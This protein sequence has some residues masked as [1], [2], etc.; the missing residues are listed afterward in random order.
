M[1]EFMHAGCFIRITQDTDVESPLTAYDNASKIVYNCQYPLGDL[2]H[3]CSDPSSSDKL[4]LLQLMGEEK[5]IEYFP[6]IRRLTLDFDTMAFDLDDR[7]WFK[8]FEHHFENK[9][10]IVGLSYNEYS[11]TPLRTCSLDKNI[12]GYAYMDLN[13][14]QDNWCLPAATWNTPIP[15]D[16]DNSVKTMMERALTLIEGE[17]A[18]LSMWMAGDVWGFEVFDGE[19]DDCDSI[20]SC[21]GHYGLDYCISE[22]KSVAEAHRK[23]VLSDTPS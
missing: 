17:V 23:R 8:F 16:H 6:L 9:L 7:D 4:L 22:A 21:W 5:S 13:M 18:T 2:Q 11:Y 12:D 10:A 1:N 14:A 15:Y 3:L 19:D 20:D